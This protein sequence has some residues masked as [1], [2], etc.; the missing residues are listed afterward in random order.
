MTFLVQQVLDIARIPLNDIDKVRYTDDHL[1]DY[2]RMALL[3]ARKDRPD[4]F[5]GQWDSTASDM[6][7]DDDFPIEESYVPYFADYITGRAELVDDE[8]TENARALGLIQ[9]FIAGMKT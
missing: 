5:I 8:H 3:I 2:F 9:N 6:T 4:L 1:L 7:A